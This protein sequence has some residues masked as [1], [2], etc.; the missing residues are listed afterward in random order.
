MSNEVNMSTP[1]NFVIQPGATWDLYSPGHSGNKARFFTVNPDPDPYGIEFEPNQMDL[2]ITRVWSTLWVSDT[3]ARTT[4]GTSA[5]PTPVDR[6]QGAAWSLRKP[7]TDSP[8]SYITFAPGDTD[9]E[10]SL[11]LGGLA[12]ARPFPRSA[13]GHMLS[14]RT[15][16]GRRQRRH[17]GHERPGALRADAASLIASRD[18]A[19]MSRSE[20]RHHA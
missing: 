18:A 10:L 8:V 2:E 3:G 14:Q 15:P 6:P 4:N 7:I 19:G 17:L 5:S 20:R 13:G 11:A 12:A 1:F 16:H 9:P